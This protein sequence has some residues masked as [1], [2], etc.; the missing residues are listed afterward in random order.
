MGPFIATAMITSRSLIFISA[1]ETNSDALFIKAEGPIG[2]SLTTMEQKL[3]SLERELRQLI[4]AKD[5]REIV[6]TAGH[7]D[8]SRSEI[9]E[10]QD[11]AWGMISIYLVPAKERDTHTLELRDELVALYDQR[12]GYQRLSVRVAGPSLDMGYPLQTVVIGNTPNRF[13]AAERLMEYVRNVEGVN[14]VW[15]DYVPGKPIISL[16]LDYDALARYG[17]TVG[18]V[19]SAVKVAFNGKVVDT[20]DTI[21]E[22][23]IYRIELDGVDVR[24]LMAKLNP[25]HARQ[26]LEEVIMYN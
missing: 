4:P 20:F 15:S 19:S 22:T 6:V 9:T 5:L 23:I 13:V 11:S 12:E 1:P 17:V 16:H 7:H 24:D 3:G 18:E 2:T 14:E 8:H 21:E 10:G 26:T 25:G